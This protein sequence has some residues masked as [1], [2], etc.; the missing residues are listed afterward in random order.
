[1]TGA[2]KPT[3]TLSYDYIVELSKLYGQIIAVS[4]RI[5]ALEF[6]TIVFNDGNCGC[7]ADVSIPFFF[8]FC[9]A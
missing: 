2:A 9:E 4:A 3:Q 7:P 5:S 1:M 8:M 6:D